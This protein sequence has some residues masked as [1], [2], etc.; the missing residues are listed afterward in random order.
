M[1]FYFKH[2]IKI[3]FNLITVNKSTKYIL[4]W[5][6]VRGQTRWTDLCNVLIPPKFI[7]TK[8]KDEIRRV[9]TTPGD[10]SAQISFTK[11]WG[12]IGLLRLV[13]N[14]TEGQGMQMWDLN[15]CTPHDC[16]PKAQHMPVSLISFLAFQKIILNTP[17]LR[18]KQVTWTKVKDLICDFEILENKILLPIFDFTWDVV[19]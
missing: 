15:K 16:W 11:V 1:F 7:S 10:L 18:F 9:L 5:P 13:L 8:V 2:L 19:K 4:L 6:T 12:L 3:T 14:I 17:S